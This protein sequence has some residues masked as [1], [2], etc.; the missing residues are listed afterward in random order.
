MA[1][2]DQTLSQND[3][4]RLNQ[5]MDAALKNFQ[6]IEDLQLSTKDAAKA[7]AEDFGWKAGQLIKAARTAYKASIEDEKEA[8]DIVEEILVLT[9]RR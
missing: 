8:F 9:N 4:I 2:A 7:L 6:D 3:K 5:F 1:I